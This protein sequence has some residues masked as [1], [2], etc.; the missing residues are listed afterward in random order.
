MLNFE[1]TI[2]TA[3]VTPLALRSN[4]RCYSIAFH[5]LTVAVILNSNSDNSKQIKKLTVTKRGA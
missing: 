2:L 4:G 1:T 3:A 5:A